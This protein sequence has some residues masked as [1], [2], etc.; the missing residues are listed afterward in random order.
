MLTR[1]ATAPVCA[2]L[3]HR[4]RLTRCRVPLPVLAA[5]SD[6]LMGQSPL[7]EAPWLRHSRMMA[8]NARRV[9]RVSAMNKVRECSL[10]RACGLQP[11]RG[12]ARRAHRTRS[13]QH[14][15]SRPTGGVRR[16]P[17]HHGKP[18]QAAAL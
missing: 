4:Q 18:C 12:A 10:L 8:Y 16:A 11:S 17:G 1:L 5:M 7:A 13:V 3:C 2:V 15:H 14:S 9:Q 6:A